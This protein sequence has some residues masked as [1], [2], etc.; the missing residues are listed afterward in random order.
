[1]NNERIV[2]SLGATQNMLQNQVCWSNPMCD[3]W[4]LTYSS[5]KHIIMTISSPLRLIK[6]FIRVVMLYIVESSPLTW[7]DIFNLHSNIEHLIMYLKQL[8][9]SSCLIVSSFASQSYN[10]VSGQSWRKVDFPLQVWN[11]FSYDQTEEVSIV[12]NALK[13]GTIECGLA[14]HKNPNCGG[15]LFDKASGSCSMKHV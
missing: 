4:K 1:M 11:L 3:T 13:S 15:F 6:C 5:Q 2:N 7:S 12:P 14:C 8:V 10:T 9:F